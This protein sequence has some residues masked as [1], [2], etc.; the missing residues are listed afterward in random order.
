MINGSGFSTLNV[1]N[2]D[3]TA[4]EVKN[5][6]NGVDLSITVKYSFRIQN[7]GYMVKY[8]NIPF[9]CGNPAFLS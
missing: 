6:E 9:D 7:L 3:I 4:D 1:A 5:E 8:V 2:K